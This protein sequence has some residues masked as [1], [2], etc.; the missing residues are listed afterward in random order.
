VAEALAHAH[1]QGI[2]HRD[3]KPSNLLLDVE[4]NIW[5]TDFGLA[6]SDDSEA[7]TE[8]GDIVGTLRYMAPER[9][10]GD[11]GP[12]SDV[13]GLGVT[14]YELLT[15]RPAFDEGDRARLIDHI[16]HTDPPPPRAVD[17]KIQRDL[18][19]IV[20]KAMAKHPA[21]RYVS[22]RALAEDLER[23]L[24]DRTILARR[25]SV[26]ERLW[27]WC[28]RNPALAAM[29]LVVT[30]ALM[31]L[32]AGLGAG[33]VLLGRA[34]A[35]IAEQRARAD[36]NFREARRA[37]DDY[38]TL[39]S[40][41]RL[42]KSPVPGLQPLRKE[43][44]ET[45]LRYYQAF[46]AEHPDEPAVRSE[47]A[48]AYFRVGSI[49]EEV[50]TKAEAFRA[51]EASRGLCERLV[52]EQPDNSVFRQQL[53]ECVRNI[54]R[55][56][57][58]FLGQ[59]AEGLQALLQ[60]Q[61]LYEQLAR[62]EAKKTEFLCGLAR[63]YADLG[64]CHG[65]RSQAV[66][67]LAFHQKALSIW[68][69]LAAG[70]RKFRRDL[71]TTA[72]NMGYCYTRSGQAPEALK[73]FERSLAIFAQLSSEDPS[74]TTSLNE[75]CRVYINIAYVHRTLTRQYPE[76]LQAYHQSRQI[77]ERLARDHPAVT[78][79]QLS[80]AAI[81]D[82]IGEVF[83][84]TEQFTE[85]K[86][87]LQQAQ[88]ILERV[89]AAD[90]SNSRARQYCAAGY[91]R[92]GH[93]ELG[94]KRFA[95]ALAF[96]R[97][98][99]TIFEELLRGDPD[100]LEN[101]EDLGEC[102]VL[103]AE[104]HEATGQPIEAESSYQRAITIVESTPENSLR[105]YAP[106]LGN[107]IEYYTKLGHLQ[108]AAGQRAG[109][110][111]SYQQVLD[112]RQRFFCGDNSCVTLRRFYPAWI[113]LGQLQIDSGKPDQGR[114]TLQPARELMEKL[115]PQNGEDDYNLACL[116]AQVS[117]LVGSGK[118]CLTEQQRAERRACLDRALGALRTAVAA[119]HQKLARLMNDPSLDPLR[120]RGD[121]QK[122]LEA[123]EK[124]ESEA[125]SRKSEVKKSRD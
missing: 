106:M 113:A 78:E 124:Q 125:R 58:R 104:V 16:L 12:G 95:E 77:N 88:V 56:Q 36:Q 34:N 8:A 83:L 7:L 97:R 120:P 28:K 6:K 68:A 109:A 94:L 10:Y 84:K 37:V 76:A 100:Q 117:R 74:D 2:L 71:G 19:T 35:R 85:A 49:Q 32:V 63:T 3:I 45:A 54:G 69:R 50:A 91:L 115:P 92:F 67:E 4:G 102:L 42:L 110:E 30:G 99:Q 119:G 118:T 60:A 5:V 89:V 24:Q 73:S 55:M 101:R 82:Q 65:I 66:D 18:E 26:S 44:L 43:L 53:A 29:A 14:L 70:D 79:F 75:L 52:C 105:H 13:Y 33:L 62:A 22:A 93:A 90:P 87:I 86:E 103:D 96:S 59:P 108:R 23:F 51:Y 122:L 64:Y 11:S 20:L 48:W 39:V 47:L 72:I 21:D 17:T 38:L 15:L 41:N 107:L 80:K 123:A 111:R 27:R 112:I 98:A 81:Y 1:G 116:Q 40:E 46:V 9:F 57:S 121:F 31:L 25:S 114:Q 61:D